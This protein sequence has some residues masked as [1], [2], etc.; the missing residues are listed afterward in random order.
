MRFD[1]GITQLYVRHITPLLDYLRSEKANRKEKSV[2][3]VPIPVE[4][5][6]IRKNIFGQSLNFFYELNNRTKDRLDCY[7]KQL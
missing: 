5:L 1:I 6:N 2:N 4:F 3:E 7:G